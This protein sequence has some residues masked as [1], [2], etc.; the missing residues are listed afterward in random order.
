MGKKP[1]NWLN[2]LLKPQWVNNEIKEES[3]NNTK[4]AT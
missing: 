2:M 1:N 4:Y 3:E